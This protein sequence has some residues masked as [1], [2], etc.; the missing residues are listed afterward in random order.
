MCGHEKP[1][2]CRP[3]A[4]PF[5]AVSKY[6]QVSLAKRGAL[7]TRVPRPFLDARTRSGQCARGLKLSLGDS[8]KVLGG[9]G[10][11]WIL[12]LQSFVYLLKRTLVK[13]A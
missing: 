11:S 2:V 13:C 10:K 7:P 3:T 4:V 12:L 5:F 9:N 1:Q 6:R 8:N